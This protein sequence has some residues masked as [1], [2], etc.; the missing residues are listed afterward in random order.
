MAEESVVLVQTG[1][2]V[3]DHAQD[4]SRAVEVGWEE[5]VRSAANRLLSTESWRNDG[6]GQMEKYRK[7]EYEWRLEIRLVEPFEEVQ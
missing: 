7:G 4:V 5:T 1:V 3:G 2:N 6:N